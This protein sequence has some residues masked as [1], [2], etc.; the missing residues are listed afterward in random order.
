MGETRR[1]VS[2]QVEG[3]VQGWLKP[4]HDLC[5]SVAGAGGVEVPRQALGDG[6]GLIG[7]EFGADH[8]MVVPDDQQA[9]GPFEGAEEADGSG[10]LRVQRRSFPW[11]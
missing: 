5:G 1:P 6:A 7:V 9:R 10:G 8:A 11:T 4:V 3:D 2:F